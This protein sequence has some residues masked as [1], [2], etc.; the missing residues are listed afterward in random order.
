VEACGAYKLAGGCATSCD[1]RSA[2]PAGAEHRYSPE[3]FLY[4]NNRAVGREHLRSILGLSGS[5]DRF[6]G[7][8]PYWKDWKARIDVRGA[9]KT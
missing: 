6:E 7:T 9:G 4:H 8:G 2:C 1:A 5:E 3:Q